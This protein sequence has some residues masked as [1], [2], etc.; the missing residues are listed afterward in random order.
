PVGVAQAGANLL[1]VLHRILKREQALAAQLLK[2]PAFEIFEYE[3]M[4]DSAVQIPRGAVPETADDIRVT[5]AVERDGLILE[6]FDK[7]SFEVVI[8]IVLQKNIKGFDYDL[9]VRRL[10]RRKRVMGEE[11][12]GIAAATQFPLD[13]ISPVKPAI[14]Q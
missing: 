12:L 3:I 5:D 14:T 13:V 4:K 1:N 11:D 6:I 8:K 9:S 2:V 7:R 10:R